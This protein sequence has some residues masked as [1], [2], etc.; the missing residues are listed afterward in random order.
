[1]NRKSV[2]IMRTKLYEIENFRSSFS[3]NSIASGSYGVSRVEILA[4]LIILATCAIWVLLPL[5]Q[6]QLKKSREARC[7]K[8]LKELNSGLRIYVEEEGR[9]SYFP[10]ANGG[11][12]LT[13]L[14]QTDI[15]KESQLFVCP[16]TSDKT[17]RKKLLELCGEDS[18]AIN[19]TSYA[20]RK[21]ATLD[22][23]GIYVRHTEILTSLISDDFQ[24]SSNH[25]NGQVIMVAHYDGHVDGY[26]LWDAGENDYKAFATSDSCGR[27]ADPLTN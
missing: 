24:N 26:R 9:R 1:M 25:E 2:I 5:C 27:I 18:E 20:G 6:Y 7:L 23:P 14:Y 15:I 13:R 19:T 17:S 10:D 22:Y 16:S 4:I 12:F 21:N 11:N 8:N 3:H